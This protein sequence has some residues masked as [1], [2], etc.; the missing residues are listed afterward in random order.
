[1]AGTHPEDVE[2]LAYVDE[3]LDATR[4]GEIAAHMRTCETCASQVRDLAAARDALRAAPL[5]HLPGKR[6]SSIIG[7][8]P[9]P[10]QPARARPRRLLALVTVLLVVAAVLAVVAAQENG[11]TVGGEAE[12]AAEQAPSQTGETGRDRT[13]ETGRDE[14]GEAGRADDRAVPE[15]ALSGAPP[16]ARVDGPPTRVADFLREQGYDARVVGRS[17][18]VRTR[19]RAAVQRLL[20]GRFARG[21]VAVYVR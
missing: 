21:D 13:G 7:G 20:T 18:E 8:L 2:L 9:A 3:E 6:R 10:D 11:P 17:V 12:R 15:A 1:M 16:V 4:A 14:T 19:R 5:L